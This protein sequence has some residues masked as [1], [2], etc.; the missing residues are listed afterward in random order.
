[1]M[2]LVPCM[3]SSYVVLL[4]MQLAFL[5]KLMLKLQKLEAVVIAMIELLIKRCDILIQILE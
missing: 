5:A 4:K 3:V 1:M 2:A